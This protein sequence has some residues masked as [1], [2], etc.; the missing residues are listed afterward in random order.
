MATKL[1]SGGAYACYPP[2]PPPRNF[3]LLITVVELLL[4]RELSG[5][6]QEPHREG[7]FVNERK[8]LAKVLALILLVCADMAAAVQAFA[9]A[10]W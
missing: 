1:L 7:T 5:G 10:A 3:N 9:Q 6:P 8:E 2:P 4:D